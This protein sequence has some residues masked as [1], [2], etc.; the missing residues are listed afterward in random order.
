MRKALNLLL[1]GILAYQIGCTSLPDRQN[2]SRYLEGII[3]SKYRG[4]ARFTSFQDP[5]YTVSFDIV[6]DN[7]TNKIT[8][9]TT[10]KIADKLYSFPKGAKIRVVK[11]QYKSENRIFINHRDIE[12]VN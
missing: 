8:V 1:S 11:P 10:K 3:I 7:T 4:E 9:L 5:L 6:Y 12:R 2:N